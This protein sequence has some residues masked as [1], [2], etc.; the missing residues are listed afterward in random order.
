[1]VERTWN[2]LLRVIEELLRVPTHRERVAI[3][4][5]TPDV[6][7]GRFAVKRIV[8]DTIVVEVDAFTYGHDEIAVRLDHRR[9]GKHRWQST[10]MQPLGNDR[11]RG[12]L[13]AERIGELRFRVVAW[14]DPVAT[15]QHGII[16]KLDAG[17]DVEL[18]REEGALLAEAYAKRAR[19]DDA[20]ALLAW[21]ERLRSPQAIDASVRGELD[22]FLACTR[23][24]LDPDDG[25]VYDHTSAIRVERAL[26]GCA[27]WYEL[28][29]RS[30]SPDPRRPG[31]LADVTTR[32]DAIA[33]MGFDVVYLPPIHPIGFAHRKGA[34]NTTTAAPG[35]PG[36]PWAIGSDDGGHT[37]VHPALGTIAD[38]DRLVAAAKARGIEIAL[39]LAFQA[40]PDH[41]WIREHP[42]WFRHRP[43]GSVAYAENPPKKY[44]DI[45]P[46]DFDSEDAAGLWAALLEVVR[47]WIDHG[48]RVFRVDNP[49]TKPFAFWEWL[50]TQTLGKEPDVVFLAEAFTRPRVMEQLAKIGFTQSYTYFTWRNTKHE[51]TEYFT[52]LTTPP[53]SDYF[54][55]NVWP[56]TPDILNETLQH[57]TR[58]TFIA[59]AVLAAGLASVYGVYGPAFELQE[60]TPREPG[61]E[62]YLDSEKYQIRHWD[63]E[64]PDSLRH[65][66]ARLNAVRRAHPALQRNDTLRFHHI[67]NDQLLCWSKSTAT[68]HVLFFVNLDPRAVQSGWTGLDLSCL[69]VGWDEQFVVRDLV[70]G[71]AY[72]WRGPHNFVLLDPAAV[73]AHVFAVERAGADPGDTVTP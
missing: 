32:L 7:R 51:L 63:T 59:R 70:T 3:E 27:A 67:D 2:S 40:S 19:T 48:V 72:D 68:D 44:E 45:V 61:S 71:V 22:E 58:G 26:A 36:S 16:A 33:E 10:W 8:G 20:K 15:W 56:N 25:H 55:P 12:E 9:R 17:L 29:P 52:E 46:F 39:D 21:A 31:T 49:H 1:L 64:R 65:F 34:N 43:D 41:P 30:S 14:R 60:R 57:G 66:L 37:A 11:W 62:E 24:V 28:F 18:E 42:A 47:F 54:R 6:E 13:T 69:G 23:A 73:P 35:D 53:L 4:N 5:V 38:F 50:I